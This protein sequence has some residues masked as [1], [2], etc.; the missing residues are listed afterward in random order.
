MSKKNASYDD[1]VEVRK[2]VRYGF[3]AGYKERQSLRDSIHRVLRD[4]EDE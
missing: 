3:P 1:K 4:A 2:A